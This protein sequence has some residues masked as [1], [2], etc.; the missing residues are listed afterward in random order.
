VDRLERSR[1]S[2]SR[3]RAG[4]TARVIGWARAPVH[5]LLEAPISSAPCIFYFVALY[6]PGQI[7]LG[8]NYFT[9]WERRPL[10]SRWRCRGEFQLE[11]D[12]GRAAVQVP[13]T[14][15]QQASPLD[16]ATA[17]TVRVKTSWR[18]MTQHE[19]VPGSREAVA[20]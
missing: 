20:L 7:R 3:L 8:G 4:V 18:N 1:V 5:D 15:G 19:V 10:A 13:V 17:P 16:G 2:V 14:E 11:D 12:T 6:E 9:H